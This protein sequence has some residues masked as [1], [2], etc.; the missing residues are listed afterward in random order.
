[1]SFNRHSL[2]YYA[3]TL[4]ALVL[5]SCAAR[6]A[7][8]DDEEAKAEKEIR[9]REEAA[10]AAKDKK[11]ADE[12]AKKDA[13]AKAEAAAKKGNSPW[14]PYTPKAVCA[15]CK[16]LQ[17]VPLLPYKPYIKHEGGH[18]LA[19]DY[20]PHWKFCEKCKADADAK[21]AAS[22]F[23][24]DMKETQER[25]RQRTAHYEDMV[26]AKLEVLYTPFVTV[27]SMLNPA[28]NKKIGDALEKCADILSKNSKSMV[29]LCTRPDRNGMVMIADNATYSR[30][31]DKTFVNESQQNRDLMRKGTGFDTHSQNGADSIQNMAGQTAGAENRAVF[32][33][34]KQIM[35][36]ATHGKARAWLVE[37]FA[38]YCEKSTLGA[39][40]MYSFQY[41][42]N[43]NVHLGRDW[44]ED[45]R[46]QGPLKFKPWPELFN[47]NLEHLQAV[48]YLQ[49][50]AM[51]SFLIQVDPS[52]FDKLV[53]AI[54]DGA[55][56]GPAI[57]AIY[58]RKLDDVMPAFNKWMAALK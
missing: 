28:T 40:T 4:S 31:I 46:R 8:V 11:A 35:T 37:G 12:A 36:T 30:F 47:Q 21:T 56:S 48:Q 27:R 50:Y 17:I 14:E 5:C 25:A 18:A 23:S 15:S 9:K 41:D 38:A 54:A 2:A 20:A 49:F 10:K 42:P 1:M 13:V 22:D 29:L 3:I 7:D 19:A 53:L 51:V 33:W 44:N 43:T 26:G 34:G 6:A 58:G 24:N 57:E 32:G 39:N 55:E 52:R 16:D 45:V